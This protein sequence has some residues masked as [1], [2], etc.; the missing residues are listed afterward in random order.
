MTQD[1][2]SDLFLMGEL[3]AA[4]RTNDPDTF[5]RWLVGGM[6]DLGKLSVSELMTDWMS[7]LL[8]P[9]DADGLMAWHL[10]IELPARASLAKSIEEIQRRYF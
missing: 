6:E 3:V 8:T 1:T 4:R 7:P 2:R 5:K 10:D 9:E